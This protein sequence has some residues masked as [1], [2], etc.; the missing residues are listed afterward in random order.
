MINDGD[1]NPG[2]DAPQMQAGRSHGADPQQQTLHQP[3][4]AGHIR[5]VD[6]T[7]GGLVRAT[8]GSLAAALAWRGRRTE[9][10]TTFQRPDA[11][12]NQFCETLGHILRGGD[13]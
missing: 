6:V 1:E 11:R 5:G 4:A 3:V 9:V 2:A 7:P 10:T 8:L 12:A 13:S